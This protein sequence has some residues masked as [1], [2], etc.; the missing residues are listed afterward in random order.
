MGKSGP[1][2]CRVDVV[3]GGGGG[4]TFPS[5]LRHL[6]HKLGGSGPRRF[7]FGEGGDG[8]ADGFSL[9]LG[10]FLLGGLLLGGMT[11]GGGPHGTL[12]KKWP[13][14]CRF[15]EE[16]D[17]AAFALPSRGT[18]V[19]FLPQVHLQN[20]GVAV[21]LFAL[22]RSNKRNK[23]QRHPVRWNGMGGGEHRTGCCESRQ[24]A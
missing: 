14:R 9:P 6:V 22:V 15:A 16:V 5:L 4:T 10:G 1:R 17:D 13:R 11:L 3:D 18:T 24:G 2:R 12:G 8:V 20:V 23:R 19:L 21:Q 7:S